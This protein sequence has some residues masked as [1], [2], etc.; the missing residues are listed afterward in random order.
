MVLGFGRSLLGWYSDLL[1]R[2]PFVTNL[3]S[4]ATVSVSGDLL[5]QRI[6]WQVHREDDFNSNRTT[7]GTF[8]QNRS[9]TML[10]WGGIIT[11]PIWLTF[12]RFVDTRLSAKNMKNVLIK[13]GMAAALMTPPMNAGY[14]L[15]CTF[16]ENFLN[17]S[18]KS[19]SELL[20]KAQE[21]I[22]RDLKEIVFSSWKV[23][24]PLNSLNWYFFPNHL[25]LVVTT[26][27]NVF[28]N[29]YISLVQHRP[30]HPASE[31]SASTD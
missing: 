3:A 1:I 4:S 6:Q 2:R 18:G 10:A 24:I 26:I 17:C 15:F 14:I 19:S 21:G 5:A 22:E 12:Y 11:T 8:D 30:H 28:W 27:G 31:N 7:S 29:A 25:R 16:F 23:W 20:E 13:V 9:L